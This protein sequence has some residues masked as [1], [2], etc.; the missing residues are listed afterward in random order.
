MPR[1]SQLFGNLRSFGAV[2]ALRLRAEALDAMGDPAAMA[3][4]RLA[5]DAA[6]EPDSHNLLA[7]AALAQVKQG[8]PKGAL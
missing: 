6:G 4:Y 3:A 7:K 8:D 1:L 5:A 2:V